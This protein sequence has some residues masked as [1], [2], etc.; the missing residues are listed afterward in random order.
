MVDVE[1][2]KIRKWADTGDRTDPDDT[3]LNPTLARTTGWPSGFSATDGDTPRRRVMNQLFRELTGLAVDTMQQGVLAWD[4]NIDYITNGIVQSGGKLYRATV[5]TGPASS[6]ATDPASSGQTIW[7]EVKGVLTLAGAPDAPSASTSTPGALLWS[8]GLPQDGGAKITSFDFQWRV[9]TSSTWSSAISVS[10]AYYSLTGLTNGTAYQA[11]VRAVTTQGNGPWSAAGSGTP[12]AQAPSGG[13]QFGLQASGGDTQAT[14]TWLEPATNGAAITGY[15]YQWKSGS[16]S[17]DPGRQG[18]ATGLTTTITG[19]TNDTEYTFRVRATNSSGDSAW[20]NEA[21]ATP[22]APAVTVAVPDAGVAPVAA[23]SV[24]GVLD[25][26]WLSPSDNGADLTGYDFQQRE[27]GAASWGATRALTTAYRRETGLANGTTYEARVRAKNSQGAGAWSGAGTGTPAAAV[28]D[29]VSYIA[30]VN[31]LT[32]I[33]ASWG[34]PQNNGAA[35]SG[36][37]LQVDTTSGFSSPDEHALTSTSYTKAGL[38]EGTTYYFRVRAANSAGDGA[39]SPVASLSWNDGQATPGAPGQPV[40]D[41]GP[42]KLYWAWAQ[43]TLNGGTFTS[44]QFQQRESGSSWGSAVTTLDKPFVE[45]EGLT[46]G[47]TYE[48]RARMVSSV[49]TGAWSSTGSGVA[50]AVVEAP[51]TITTTTTYSWP[52]SATRG[53]IRAKGSPLKSGSNGADTVVTLGS[54]TVTAK[55]AVASVNGTD[56]FI[57]DYDDDQLWRINPSDPDDTSGD[58][59]LVGSLPADITSPDGLAFRPSDGALF[60][61]NRTDLWRINPADPDDETGVYG[62]VGSFP[63]GLQYGQGMAFRPSDGAL[64]VTDTTGDELWRINPDAPG[65]TDGDYGL[66]GSLPSSVTFPDGLSFRKSDSALFVAKSNEL[67]RINPADPDDITGDYGLVGSFPSG[68]QKAYDLAFRPSDGA[69]FVA[70][71]TD[72]QLWR[73]NPAD[74]EDETGVYGLVGSLPS[75]LALADGLAFQ[76]IVYS[77]PTEVLETVESLSAGSTFSITASSGGEATIYPTP[78]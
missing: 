76:L 2:R 34:A 73:I 22:A 61:S 23:S 69:L 51:I 75:S 53:V 29:A 32:G 4:T 26:S 1:S 3:T 58:Y 5:A 60:V 71:Y 68:L 19:L 15:T 41:A 78:A 6:N 38:T 25:W 56:L 50:G 18:T 21:A 8:W 49:G 45:V 42:E 33:T 9:A 62:R 17:Y 30:L 24:P 35:V 39:W 37:L 63:S 11:R 77:D 14:L 59:G 16:Q 12:V 57:T 36:Y 46:P 70:D 13:A 10:T 52:H 47:R 43:A 28:P 31:G 40:S 54:Q 44:Y 66:V 7:A 67:W 65:N 55:G 74:P 20:S 48:A 27:S 64:F 72:D